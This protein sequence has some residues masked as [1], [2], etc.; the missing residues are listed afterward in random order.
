MAEYR[1]TMLE[2]GVRAVQLSRDAITKSKLVREGV[3]FAYGQFSAPI[4]LEKIRL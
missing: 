2:R 4:P 1:D 3:P